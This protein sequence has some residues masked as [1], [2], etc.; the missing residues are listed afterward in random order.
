[1]YVCI[2]NAL[3]ERD[4][5]AAIAEGA[6]NVP[7]VYRGCGCEP[8]CGRC[9]RTIAEILGTVPTGDDGHLARQPGDICLVAAE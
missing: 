4:V 2:C 7:S 9:S 6:R 8:Q 5:R 1:M 3:T